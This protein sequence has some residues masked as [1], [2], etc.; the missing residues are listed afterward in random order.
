MRFL[1]TF[2]TLCCLAACQPTAAIKPPAPKA[3][4]ATL[5]VAKASPQA[6]LLVVPSGATV[7]AGA[8]QVD[9]GYVVQAGG[10]KIIASNGASLL[11]AGT[12]LISPNGGS[13]ISPDGARILANNA[14]NV[15]AAK[16]ELISERGN[17][18]I[19]PNGGQLTGKV[20]RQLLQAGDGLTTAAGMVVGLRS[21]LTGEFVEI[22]KDESGQPAY[23]LY[24]NLKGEYRFAVPADV[25]STVELVALAPG[26][27]DERLSYSSLTSSAA[28]TATR[29]DD[30]TS[31]MAAYVREAVQALML[32]I[33]QGNL[34]AVQA[35]LPKSASQQL[36]PALKK[37]IDEMPATGPKSW[38]AA[39]QRVQA[40]RLAERVLAEVTLTA[41]L[42]DATLV[43]AE[44]KGLHPAGADC[45]T[46]LG[47]QMAHQRNELARRFK[48]EADPTVF[49][50]IA[51]V[52]AASQR[53]GVTYEI[54]RPAD[55]GMFV[56]RTIVGANAADPVKVD[57]AVSTFEHELGLHGVNGEDQWFRAVL[58]GLQNQ[59]GFAFAA[60]LVDGKLDALIHA[61]ER[62][63]AS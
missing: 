15:V 3:S 26:V 18:L 53:D 39:E 49:S 4:T 33:L 47:V 27:A 36:T 28:G 24:T 10:G 13:L 61:T 2:L 40:R 9:A 48:E 62:P 38:T 60:L 6:A 37:A 35:S 21:L 12:A 32:P 8:M 54:K 1:P 23:A 63:K 16:S 11:T 34:A 22:G 25:A 7:I 31:V 19:A 43:S 52:T 30:D 14:G 56:A 17:G 44:F 50:R 45:L 41:A 42:P 29:V 57:A 46:I 55:Y 20:K 59:L 5:P 51:S 58:Q